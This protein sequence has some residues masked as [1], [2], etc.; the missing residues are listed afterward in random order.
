M[1][2]RA[3]RSPRR[4]SPSPFR[5]L[6]GQRDHLGGKREGQCAACPWECPPACM[7]G[8]ALLA[9]CLTCGLV[10]SSATVCT[11][12]TRCFWYCSNTWRTVLELAMTK[13][14]TRVFT[15]FPF[16]PECVNPPQPNVH[17]PNPNAMAMAMPNPSAGANPGRALGT[18][19]RGAAASRPVPTSSR[20]RQRTPTR[21]GS[22]HTP[23]PTAHAP[24]HPRRR[25]LSQSRAPQTQN[26]NTKNTQT[27]PNFGHYHST[28]TALPQQRGIGVILSE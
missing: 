23:S 15:L 28:T 17:E 26:I 9:P 11:N 14:S 8:H 24:G 13:C 7:P 27:A 16:H 1:R 25:Q 2:A 4:P 5:P 6:R 10:A 12:A 3:R 18:S 21:R 22:Q 20:T 19:P